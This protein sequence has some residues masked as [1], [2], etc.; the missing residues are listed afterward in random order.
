MIGGSLGQPPPTK[1]VLVRWAQAASLMPL[2]YSSTSPLG[3]S[4]PAGSQQYDQQTVELYRAAV[5]YP[6]D[7][8]PRTST[9]RWPGRSAPASRS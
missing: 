5:D 9:N 8:S 3:V 6:R 7:A 1:E 2:M 4:N